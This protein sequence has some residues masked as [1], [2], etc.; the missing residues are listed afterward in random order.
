MKRTF[1]YSLVSD[2]HVDHAYQ[3]LHRYELN[4]NIIVAGDT[5]NNL[6]ETFETLGELQDRGHK[7]FSCEGNHEHYRNTLKGYSHTDITRA[8]RVE[9][10]MIVD[11]DDTL[12]LISVNGWYPVRSQWSWYAYMNDCRSCFGDDAM[13]A[14]KI[15]NE[16]AAYQ[17]SLV[18]ETIHSCPDRKFIV[19]THTSPCVE[20]LDP[21]YAG[22]YSNQWYWNP[23]MGKVLAENSDQILA[24]NHGHTHASTTQEVNGVLVNCNPRGYP[25]ENPDWE[26][27]T[28]T[29]SY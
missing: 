4:K 27:L 1:K 13:A 23:E 25:G 26:P 21:K 24:W 17:A 7:V 5:S 11:I 8:Y 22:E 16:L 15:V 12:T 3:G 10:P 2:L 29:L 14:A 20:T 9:Y 6:A 19:T 28:V 18:R